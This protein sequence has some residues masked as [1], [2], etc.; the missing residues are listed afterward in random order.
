MTGPSAAGSA[1]ACAGSDRYNELSTSYLALTG[2]LNAVN[3]PVE[4]A[5]APA[6]ASALPTVEGQHLGHLLTFGGAAATN[7][8]LGG[9]QAYG[10]A[11]WHARN[12]VSSLARI[13]ANHIAAFLV[14]DWYDLFQRG[15]PLNCSG[16]QNA[17]D[18]RPVWAPMQ[19]GQ[20]VTGRY[21]LLTGPWYHLAAG[22][23]VDLDRLQ[24]QWFDT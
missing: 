23:G 7:V 2:M 18:G 22:T 8:L 6:A 19:P 12:P 14:G 15:E 11:S 5:Q 3:H 10:G 9:S 16:L 13:V 20:K 17:V 21:Q 1:A 24:L 4:T